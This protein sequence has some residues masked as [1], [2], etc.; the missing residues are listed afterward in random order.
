MNNL[1]NRTVL[2]F[3]IIILLVI[4]VG[5]FSVYSIKQIRQATTHLYEH[6]DVISSQAA[7][8]KT[9]LIAMHRSMKDVALAKNADEL[10]NA[11]ARVAER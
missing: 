2:G 8:I 1:H 7:E 3:I 9:H 5:V 6:S 10:E 4:G 11:V